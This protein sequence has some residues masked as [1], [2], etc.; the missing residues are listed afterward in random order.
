MHWLQDPKQSNVDNL[1]NVS[2]EASLHFKNRDNEY[3]KDKTDELET[4]I[5]CLLACFME[6]SPS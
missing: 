3:L 1:N 5:T 4:N 2:R 6:Q